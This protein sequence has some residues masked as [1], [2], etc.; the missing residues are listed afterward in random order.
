MNQGDGHHI[1]AILYERHFFSDATKHKYDKDH[2]DISW[3]SGYRKKD[4]LGK[5]DAKMS[6]GKVDPDDIYSD[7]DSA[8][9]RLINAFRL[10]PIAA[11]RD[12]DPRGP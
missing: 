7:Y 5:A 6:D 2:P 8:Y 9:L 3:P 11:T 4:Q 1:P 10:D 12:F